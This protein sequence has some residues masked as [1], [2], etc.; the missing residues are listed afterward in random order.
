M[1]CQKCWLIT[2]S[3]VVALIG[4]FG[5][6]MFSLGAVGI[7]RGSTDTVEHLT[8]YMQYAL[9]MMAGGFTM[10]ISCL[11]PCCCVTE[12]GDGVQK[13]LGIRHEYTP[14]GY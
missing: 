1:S 6:V 3:T 4:V 8:A 10:I 12:C 13:K 11:L 7:A 9:I 2:R 14:I 5:L